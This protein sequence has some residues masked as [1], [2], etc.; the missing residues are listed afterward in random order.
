M[1]N[2]SRLIFRASLYQYFAAMVY[3]D[4]VGGVGDGS[5]LQVVVAVVARGG[6]AGGIVYACGVYIVMVAV[7][8]VSQFVVVGSVAC[9][10]IVGVAEVGILCVC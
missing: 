6:A 3:V 4:A 10:E 2:L 1:K 7:V 9:R 8:V 5:S